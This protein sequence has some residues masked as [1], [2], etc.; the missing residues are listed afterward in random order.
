MRGWVPFDVRE[1][2][3]DVQ[4]RC[5]PASGETTGVAG[6]SRPPQPFRAG[7]FYISEKLDAA[8]SA[9]CASFPVVSP[10]FFPFPGQGQQGLHNSRKTLCTKG[11]ASQAAEKSPF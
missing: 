5:N 3:I 9:E 4:A 10:W 2:E 6:G 7:S 8:E 11:T 1:A